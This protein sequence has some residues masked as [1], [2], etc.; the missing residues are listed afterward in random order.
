MQVIIY[1]SEQTYA[2][3]TLMAYITQV[4]LLYIKKASAINV[5][6]SQHTKSVPKKCRFYIY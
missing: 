6:K 3:H 1:P 2:I 4:Y 5:Y